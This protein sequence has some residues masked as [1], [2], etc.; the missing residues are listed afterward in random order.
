MQFPAANKVHVIHKTELA[1]W[2]LCSHRGSWTHTK[3]N[4]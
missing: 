1:H 2:K 4:I 3:S